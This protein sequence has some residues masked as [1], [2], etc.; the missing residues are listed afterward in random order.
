M[1]INLVENLIKYKLL[2]DD[3]KEIEDNGVKV[4]LYRIQA[5]QDVWAIKDGIKTLVVKKG[6]KGGYVKSVD[7]LA[8]ICFTLK[9][10]NQLNVRCGSWIFEDAMAYGDSKVYENAQLRG[11]VQICDNVVVCKDAV[12]IGEGKLTGSQ[13][14]N[15][16]L[17]LEDEKE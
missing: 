3:T 13:V 17:V 8:N 5:L 7:N 14:V 6:V 2:T 11:H 1:K 16:D 9:K 4:T 12:V 10:Q 15:E